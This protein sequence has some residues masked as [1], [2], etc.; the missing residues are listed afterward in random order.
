[1]PWSDLLSGPF[2]QP[3]DIALNLDDNDRT[4]QAVQEAMYSNTPNRQFLDPSTWLPFSLT[5]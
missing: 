1:M 4:G 3:M 2:G 5:P